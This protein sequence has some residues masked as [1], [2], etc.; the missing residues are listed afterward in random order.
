MFHFLNNTTVSG[1]KT[2]T[3]FAPTDLAFSHLTQ[4][5]LNTVLA[6]KDSAQQL[7]QRH[8]VPGTLFTSG[9]RFYQVKDT[10]AE[11]KTITVQK[12]GGE[13]NFNIFA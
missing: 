2:Y 13:L 3:I 7:V 12:T 4:E 5:E 9:M 11:D 1:I 10:L 8:I 6:D